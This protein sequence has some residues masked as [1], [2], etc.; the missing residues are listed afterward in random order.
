MGNE[1][2][3][4]FQ[5]LDESE[6][7]FTLW[8]KFFGQRRTWKVSDE[9]HPGISI[10]QD[11][12]DK[13]ASE[14]RKMLPDDYSELPKEKRRRAIQSAVSKMSDEDKTTY[15]NRIARNS[16]KFIALQA[17]YVEPV[18]DMPDI[19]DNKIEFYAS[20]LSDEKDSQ[21]VSDFFFKHLNA[22]ITSPE[23]SRQAEK[24]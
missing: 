16:D 9:A 23:E 11:R 22:T 10:L 21:K 15:L 5:I 13:E 8:D 12:I 17:S 3:K 19:W 2:D 4:C 24:K 18:D 1:N 7:T 14:I 20:C 6:G